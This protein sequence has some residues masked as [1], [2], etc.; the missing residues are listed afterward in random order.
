MGYLSSFGRDMTAGRGFIAIGVAVVAQNRPFLTLFYS[1]L[2]ATAITLATYLGS[3][4]FPSEIIQTIPYIITIVVLTIY[5][6][7]EKNRKKTGVL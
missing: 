1:F 3:I 6:L 2:F 4:D 5:S 7:V